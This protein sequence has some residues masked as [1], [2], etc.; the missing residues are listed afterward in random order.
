VRS[1]RAG[2]PNWLPIGFRLPI[3]WAVRARSTKS[4]C[5]LRAR[6][7]KPSRASAQKD[8]VCANSAASALLPAGGSGSGSPCRLAPIAGC[9]S[10]LG[11]LGLGGRALA[12]RRSTVERAVRGLN[13]PARLS[14]HRTGR[15]DGGMPDGIAG[16]RCQ[17]L[18]PRGRPFR[19]SSH[20]AT[21]CRWRP[22][23]PGI[24]GKATVNA[25][26]GQGFPART[27]VAALRSLTATPPLGNPGTGT[28]PNTASDGTACRLPD[29]IM[30][31]RAVPGRMAQKRFLFSDASPW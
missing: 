29:A 26:P 31:P 5:A 21:A 3:R 27:V 17:R 8:P 15:G 4:T 2:G 20:D 24:P 9:R 14:D 18:R 13:G 30:R 6:P 22:A 11:G 23:A 7:L 10:P 12:R 1:R 16:R 28:A 25:I 19:A